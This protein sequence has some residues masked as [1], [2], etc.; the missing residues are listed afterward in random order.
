LRTLGD[1]PSASLYHGSSGIQRQPHA[2]REAQTPDRDHFCFHGF[3]QIS[4]PETWRAAIGELFDYVTVGLALSM[5]VV[6]LGRSS[7]ENM[8][9]HHASL[10]D[11]VL[12]ILKNSEV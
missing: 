2:A 12:A 6:T 4:P 1:T 11:S 3:T 7:Q 8:G 5:I 10:M 9:F